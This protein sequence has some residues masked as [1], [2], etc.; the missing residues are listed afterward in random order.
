MDKHETSDAQF[1]ISRR[2]A[3]ATIGVLAASAA[4]GLPPVAAKSA[5][6]DLAWVPAWQ[7]REMIV[8][9]Q[10][11]SVAVTEHLLARIE[12]LEPKLHMFRHLDVAG[13][14]KQAR[15]ADRLL[16]EGGSPGPLHGV[17]TAI[18]EHVAVRGMPVFDPMAG[19]AQAPLSPRDSIVVERLRRAGAV[20][21]GITVMPGLGVGPGMPDL[22]RHPR[23]PWDLERVPG[24][25]SAGSAAAVASGCL[26]FAV[27]SDG[28]GSTRL[29]AAYTGVIGVHATMGRVPDFD[30]EH[31]QL[32]LFSTIGP[33]T[34]DVRDAAL[35][36]QV[37]AGPDGRA[38]LSTLHAPVPDYVAG[39]DSGVRGMKVQWMDDL[40]FA[41]QYATDQSSR[42]IA[43]VRQAAAGLSELGVEL[44][45]GKGTWSDPRRYSSMV[46]GVYSGTPNPTLPNDD[47]LLEALNTRERLHAD[48]TDL[49]TRFDVLALPTAQVAAPTLVDWDAGWTDN[50]MQYSQAYTP[51]TLMFN[52]LAMPAISIPCGFVDG[53]P[54]GM[55]LV[56]LPDS[57]P[58]LLAL[59]QA[60]MKRFPQSLQ[61]DVA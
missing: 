15:A 35:V 41:S 4:A 52:F 30:I 34:R 24:G 45:P 19:G 32:N 6:E 57:E 40:G 2:Q 26:P 43:A 44:A 14:L 21:I 12:R 37:I 9:G 11:S 55:Q 53:M 49:L 59:A 56:G 31:R 50:M 8:N 61:P 51:N 58:R 38:M 33:L 13:A 42:V 46:N 47:Q 60:Y 22:S 20:I 25:S 10:V 7:L 48:F 36:M 18:K 54:V 39:L 27:G 17:P 28:G 16:A 29:P 1:P 3:M 5:P 23:N